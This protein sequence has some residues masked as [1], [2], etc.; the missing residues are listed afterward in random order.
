MSIKDYNKNNSFFNIMIKNGYI[1][2]YSFQNESDLK[3]IRSKI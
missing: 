3:L 2:D 1:K